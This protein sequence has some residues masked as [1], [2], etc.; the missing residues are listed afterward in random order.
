MKLFAQEKEEK[1][2]KNISSSTAEVPSISQPEIKK[3]NLE[4]NDSL[5]LRSTKRNVNVNA[6]SLRNLSIKK[7]QVKPESAS[8]E[9]KV[10]AA[11]LNDAKQNLDEN[12]W[13]SP[14]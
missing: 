6:A 7:T 3:E 9:S 14:I 12:V 5:I 4:S 8:E 2:A 10:L 1:E 13:R 11:A